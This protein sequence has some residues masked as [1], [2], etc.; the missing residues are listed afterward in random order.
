MVDADS[1]MQTAGLRLRIT[2]FTS[3]LMRK[4][5]SGLPTKGNVSNHGEQRHFGLWHRESGD[6]FSDLGISA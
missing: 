3:C 5:C 4:I 2:P 6:Y 1:M